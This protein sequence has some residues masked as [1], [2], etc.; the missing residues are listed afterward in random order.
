MHLA[1]RQVS[2]DRMITNTQWLQEKSDAYQEYYPHMEGR[3][4]SAEPE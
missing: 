3:R 1:S 4:V 2:D